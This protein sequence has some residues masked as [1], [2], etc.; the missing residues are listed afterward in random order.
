MKL[1]TKIAAAVSTAYAI[2]LSA[3]GLSIAFNEMEFVDRELEI[4]GRRLGRVVAR[5]V[6]ETVA[7]RGEE[8]AIELLTE[9]DRREP[10]ITIRHFDLDTSETERPGRALGVEARANLARGEVVGRTG[11]GDDHTRYTY[12]P[13]EAHNGS[14]TRVIEIAESLHARDAHVHNLLLQVAVAVVAGLVASIAVSFVLGRRLV[15]RRID[16]LVATA[17]SIG[18]GDYTRRAEGGPPDEI[19]QLAQAVN[20]MADQLSRAREERRCAEE[21]LDHADRLATLGQIASGVAHEIGTP[22]QSITMRA[23]LIAEEA[24]EDARVRHHVE[25]V[26]QQSNRVAKLVRNLLRF[27]RRQ[28]AQR[29]RHDLRDVV[30][31]ALSLIKSVQRPA[32][33]DVIAQLPEG[34]VIAWVQAEPIGQVLTNLILNGIQ[35]TPDGGRI[36]VSLHADEAR[37]PD[38]VDHDRA[39]YH[40]ITV[41]DEG[42]G[43]PDDVLPHVFEAF[44]TTKD[45]D[46]GTGLGLSVVQRIVQ[47]H[48]GFVDLWSAP[49]EGTRF[50]VFL[51]ALRQ[52]APDDNQQPGDCHDP[53]ERRLEPA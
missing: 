17:R 6:R 18:A 48:D 25:S 21:A 15:G 23:G 32:N 31:D 44:F 49:G 40:R 7:A 38:A 12:V 22:L 53:P 4:H 19:G 11:A 20:E 39:P 42:A 29:A 36:T 45:V 30:T 34:P 47:E 35:A 1:A 3:S 9:I 33:V 16:G 14:V 27:A 26:V 28:P 5:T 52:D 43:I 13:V 37:T 24:K 41:E 10:R 50:D 51:P 46:E 8:A 2:V